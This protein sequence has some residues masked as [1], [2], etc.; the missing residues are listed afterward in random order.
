MIAGVDVE[1][2]E[3]F[4]HVVRKVLQRFGHVVGLW[5][6]V[7]ALAKTAL[8][9]LS[10]R[11]LCLQLL[12]YVHVTDSSTADNTPSYIIA[13]HAQMMAHAL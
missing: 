2:A 8:L 1:R 11:F 12:I 3:C 10:I 13:S 5:N 9:D 4:D 7:A 6:I